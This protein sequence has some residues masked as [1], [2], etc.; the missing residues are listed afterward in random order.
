MEEDMADKKVRLTITLS[1]LAIRKLT[2]WANAHEKS[3]TAWAAQLVESEI[4]ANLDLIE[5]LLL[6]CSRAKG[7]SPEE[8]EKQWREQKEDE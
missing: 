1:D 4:E 2:V 7:V 5:K 3:R 6:D 8:L